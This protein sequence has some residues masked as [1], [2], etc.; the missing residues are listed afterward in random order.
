MKSPGGGYPVSG[1]S[2]TVTTVQGTQ[3][4]TLCFCLGV[5][6]KACL[7]G[8]ILGQAHF[9]S[10]PTPQFLRGQLKG[11]EKNETRN[12]QESSSLA[13]TLCL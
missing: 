2:G 10:F 6:N 8:N 11:A 7:L 4:L 13:S 3:S 5:F 9:T 1:H 12:T